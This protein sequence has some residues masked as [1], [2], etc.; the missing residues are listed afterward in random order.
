MKIEYKYIQSKIFTVS[1]A[2][3]FKS[4]SRISFQTKRW[5]KKSFYPMAA[6]DNF[7]FHPAGGQ[8][9]SNFLRLALL[10]ITKSFVVYTIFSRPLYCISLLFLVQQRCKLAKIGLGKIQKQPPRCVLAKTCSENMQQIYRTP[11][12][13]CDFNKAALQLY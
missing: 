4:F 11:M 8:E 6:R 3:L 1:A 7:L 13:K 9:T 5:P 2:Y 10:S 12:P